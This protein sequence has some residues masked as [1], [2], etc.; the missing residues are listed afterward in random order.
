MGGTN[1]RVLLTKFTGEGIEV[2]AVE[3]YHLPH[4]VRTGTSDQVSMR[5]VTVKV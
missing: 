2:A 3:K 4:D 5:P 1:F